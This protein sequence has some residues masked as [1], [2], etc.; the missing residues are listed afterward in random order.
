MIYMINNKCQAVVKA[1][2]IKKGLMALKLMSTINESDEFFTALE[3]YNELFWS[4][5]E[6]LSQICQPYILS[7]S[8]E[9]ARIGCQCLEEY[10]NIFKEQRTP[11]EEK[12]SELCLK[13]L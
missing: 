5:H 6:E 8:W 1:A 2:T 4:T 11:A 9:D 7:S 3:E 12:A 13:Y 10:F